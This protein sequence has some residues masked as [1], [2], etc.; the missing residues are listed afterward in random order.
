[1]TGTA[2]TTV[3]NA[4]LTVNNV[5]TGPLTFTSAKTLPGTNNTGTG[6]FAVAPGATGTPCTA[7]LVI[8][9]GSSC[10]LNIQYTPPASGP[11]ASSARVVV[12][13][14]GAA[15]ASQLSPA[16]GFNAN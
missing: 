12:T 10:T 1:V 9:A 11:V 4:T 2:D 7:N 8:A 16:P 3:K 15:T 6:T 5:G 13:D 14:T